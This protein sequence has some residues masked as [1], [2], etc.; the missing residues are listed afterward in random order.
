M[1]ILTD[2]IVKKEEAEGIQEEWRIT[3]VILNRVFAL[4]Y[5][6]TIIVTLFAVMLQAP[7]FTD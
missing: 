1:K 2:S 3:S 7:R 5:L 6:V 4:I